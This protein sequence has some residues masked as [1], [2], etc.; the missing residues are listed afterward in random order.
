MTFLQGSFFLWSA[1]SEIS[2]SPSG[3]WPI[4]SWSARRHMGHTFPI[5]QLPSSDLFTWWWQVTKARDQKFQRFLIPTLETQC[6]FCHILLVR[7]SHKTSPNLK[8]GE[9][10]STSRREEQQSVLLYFLFY[11]FGLFCSI[12]Q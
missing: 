4:V 7:S 10:D 12:P 11:V 5:T 1:A 8:G 3:D 6:H 2:T 9:I